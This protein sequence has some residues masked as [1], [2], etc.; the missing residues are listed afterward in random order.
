MAFNTHVWVMIVL[1]TIWYN[2]PKVK[3]FDVLVMHQQRFSN[4][5]LCGTE[6]LYS[7]YYKYSKNNTGHITLCISKPCTKETQ[8]IVS[9]T[10]VWVRLT[11]FLLHVLFTEAVKHH[12]TVIW[13]T[14][15]LYKIFGVVT[16]LYVNFTFIKCAK[17]S[18]LHREGHHLVTFCNYIHTYYDLKGQ[19]KRKKADL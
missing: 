6:A 19:K 12:T 11:C 16:V 9:C 14:L 7:L 8:Y 5:V 2:K 18:L 13:N 10:A 1:V 4:I 17:P 3:T 15:L